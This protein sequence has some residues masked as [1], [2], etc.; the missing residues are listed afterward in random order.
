VLPLLIVAGLATYTRHAAL[1]PAFAGLPGWPLLLAL[2]LLLLTDLV[3]SKVPR[4][5]RPV[6]RAALAAAAAAGALLGLALPNALLDLAP[7]LAAATGALVAIVVQLG[8]QRLARAL[9]RPLQGQGH[10]VAGIF[11]DLA[12]GAVSAATFALSA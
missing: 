7:A 12:A 9:D 4:L 10:I 5:A 8:R 6:E 2:A 3:A 11:A 1:T